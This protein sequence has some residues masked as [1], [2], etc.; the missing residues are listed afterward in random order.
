MKTEIEVKF[1]QQDH[2]A[3]RARLSELGA[4]CTLPMV[5]MQ[6]AIIDYPDRR[7][8]TGAVNS[9]IRVRDEGSKITLTY[10]QFQSLSVDGAQ[11][12]SVTVDSFEDTVHIFT[13]IGL[14]VV[15]FQESKRETWHYKNC[16]IVLD[17]WPW[18][19]PYIEIEGES[20]TTLQTIATELGLSWDT[21]VFG[22]VMVA[23]RT[24]YPHL[25]PDQTVGKI[26]EVRFNTPLPE[27]M[28][29][30]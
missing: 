12:I 7:L 19:S 22:D 3:I 4:E 9:Y 27:S 2:D 5:L 14:D 30:R 18:L 21:A 15:S 28:Q 6:R 10:K 25:T 26:P 24:D 16:E 11:E 17:E 13:A 20:E 23:Y 1:L 29:P 8:Q